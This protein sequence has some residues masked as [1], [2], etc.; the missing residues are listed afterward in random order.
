MVRALPRL[1]SLELDPK[2]VA[3]NT[4]VIALHAA[5]FALLLAPVK[6]TAPEVSRNEDTIVVVLP[7][8]K[9]LP[10]PET[11]IRRDPLPR[12][13]PQPT[14]V[15]PLSLPTTPTETEILDPLGT[16]PAEASTPGDPVEVADSGPS[17]AELTLLSGPAPGYPGPAVRAGW[18]G[19]VVLRVLVDAQGLPQDVVIERSSGHRV[20]DQAALRQVK[21]RWR[22]QPMLR[23][24]V[25]AAAYALVPIRFNLPE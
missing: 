11:Q 23:N 5:A 6:F 24:G 22:F 25:P 3:A 14:F 16:E 4:V 7:D 12:Q 20:L 2:R 10:P 18:E 15:P 9:P 21:A 8:K 1:P 19:E 13:R 17:L